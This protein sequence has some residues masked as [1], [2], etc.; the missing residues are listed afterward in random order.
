[1]SDEVEKSLV[2]GGLLI[3]F[4]VGGHAGFWPGVITAGALLFGVALIVFLSALLGW[5]PITHKLSDG[6]AVPREG[7]THPGASTTR[8]SSFDGGEGS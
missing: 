5:S 8:G 1:M 3:S 6:S 4:G 7:G 2:V